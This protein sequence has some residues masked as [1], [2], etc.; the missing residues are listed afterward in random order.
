MKIFLSILAA[1]VVVIAL[2]VFVALS[3]TKGLPTAADEFFA[4]IAAGRL[5]EAYQATATEFR[6][7]TSA[8]EFGAFLEQSALNRYA[9]A[10]WTSRSIEN[11]LGRL[12]GTVQTQDGGEIPVKITLVKEGDVWKILAID[13]VA[14]GIREERKTSAR[15]PDIP[16]EAERSRLVKTAM[17][18]F[19]EAVI[20]GDFTA[21]HGQISRMWQQ[22]ITPQELK[23]VFSV[24]VERKIDL[25]P[26]ESFEP[27]FDADPE[28]DQDG[29]LLLV[30]HY[31]S[32]PPVQFRVKFILEKS[33]WQLFGI[34]VRL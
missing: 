13:K 11:R 27:Q 19:A 8:E 2:I 24:F 20:Q 26:L 15:S 3:A 32:D 6:A 7:A 9:R 1:V 31:P 23:N 4:H 14:A 22:Q 18:N 17:S 29:I 5:D 21:F 34:N 33:A 25:R 16:G 12:E 30:G 28:L 10:H